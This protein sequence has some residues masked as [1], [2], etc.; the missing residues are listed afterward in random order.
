MRGDEE[1]E[2]KLFFTDTLLNFNILARAVLLTGE[3]MKDR[4]REKAW[5]G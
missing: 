4:A 1:D 2:R 3:A 5:P